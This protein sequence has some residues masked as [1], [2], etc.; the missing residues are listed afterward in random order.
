MF[1]SY[2]ALVERL[3]KEQ[4]K[5]QQDR[6]EALVI[7]IMAAIQMIEEDL[8]KTLQ[9]VSELTSQQEITFDLLWTIFKPNSLIC[10]YHDFTEQNR[11][12][13]VRQVEYKRGMSGRYLQM[14]CDIIRNDGNIFGFAQDLLMITEFKGVR[15]IAELPTYPLKYH[16]NADDVYAEAVKIGRTYVQLS[17]HSY[18]EIEAGLALRDQRGR[19]GQF[20][21]RTCAIW[22][23]PLVTVLT[24]L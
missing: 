21:V 11:L 7:D 18:H 23:P 10:E 13:L 1:H 12:L 15:P 17:Q 5:G 6:R 20:Y 3:A 24:V 14:T 2:G 9:D 22:F 8:A 4:A 16:P 19:V